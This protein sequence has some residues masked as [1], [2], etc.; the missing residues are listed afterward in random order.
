ME[1]TL[2]KKILIWLLLSINLLFAFIIGLTIPFLESESRF[3]FGLIMIPLL[4]ILNYVF[5]DKFHYILRFTT[6]EEEHSNEVGEK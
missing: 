5:L 6:I 1:Q 2:K 3:N 4:T